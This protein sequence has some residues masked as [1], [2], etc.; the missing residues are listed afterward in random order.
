MVTGI[1]TNPCCIQEVTLYQDRINQ[2]EGSLKSLQDDL[3]SRKG[4]SSSSSTATADEMLQ[5]AARVQTQ[6][7]QST[8]SSLSSLASIQQLGSATH[9]QLQADTAK[10]QKILKDS[11]Q[12]EADTKTAQKNVKAIQRKG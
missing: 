12:M 6:T 1:L 9:Q 8:K 7:R 3:S 4:S 11:E 5:E 10:L 2:V